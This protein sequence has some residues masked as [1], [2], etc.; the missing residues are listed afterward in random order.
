MVSAIS[1]SQS[2]PFHKMKIRFHFFAV[3]LLSTSGILGEEPLSAHEPT[4]ASVASEPSDS[5]W[6]RFEYSTRSMGSNLDFVLYAKS[7]EEARIGI[8]SAMERLELISPFVN[9]YLP[10]SEVNQ[11]TSLPSNSPRVLSPTLALALRHSKKWFDW[12]NGAFD[13]TQRDTIQIWS[14]ARRTKS[15]PFPHELRRAEDRSVWSDIEFKET[16]DGSTTI[17]HRGSRLSLD[18]GGLA[19][20]LLLDEMMQTLRSNGI[21]SALIDA[22]GDIIASDPPPNREYWSVAIAGLELADA[23]LLNIKLRNGAVTSSGDLNQFAWIGGVR[24][25]HILDPRKR[26]PLTGR[27]SVTVVADTAMDADAGATALAVLGCEE[28]FRLAPRMPVRE[29]HYLWLPEQESTP[30]YRNW[31]NQIVNEPNR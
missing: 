24:Y 15:L 8:E 9:H 31:G 19:V 11:L 14:Q 22:G 30:H 10:D 3:Y 7:F 29:V 2:Q 13:S 6:Q 26:E 17:V 20:G 27:R 5:G 1:L 18:V 21:H 4:S 16:D 23:P 28:G 12:S 25:G